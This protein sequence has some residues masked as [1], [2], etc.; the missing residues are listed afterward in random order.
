MYTLLKKSINFIKIFFLGFIFI[1]SCSDDNTVEPA[2]PTII[3]I[4]TKSNSDSINIAGANVVLYN[5]NSGESVSRT[6]S[7]NNG[8][9]EFQNVNAGNYYVRIAA[10]GFNEIPIGNVSPVPFSVSSGQTFSRSYFLDPL[11]GTYG[12]IDGKI[13]PNLPGFLVIAKSTTTNAEVHT[14]S[15]P[16]GYF[17]LFNVPF[18]TYQ[19]NTFKSGYQPSNNPVITLS[20]NNS[21]AN[22]SINVIQIVGSK[23]NGKV[24]F[25]AAENGIV[26]ISMLDRQSLSAINGLSTKIDTSRNYS[27]SGIPNGEY[28]AW[29]SYENDGYVMDPDWVFKNPGELE[30][31]F[32]SDTTKILNFSVTD[33]LTIISPTNPA[34]SLVPALVDTTVPT[35]Y[36]NAY[37]QAKEYIIEVRDA[38]GNLMWGGF[39]NSGVINHTQIPKE[40]NSVEY[41]FDGSAV[42]PLIPGNVYQWR[43]YVDD[44][45]TANIQT[46]LSSSEDLM[47]LFIIK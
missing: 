21:S 42:S 33:A 22:T 18:D 16:D 10:Q 39:T 37:P 46:L 41:N 20:S 34:D 44:A 8:I 14:Y 24:T 38:N 9:A 29:A 47:G 40:W 27:L 28:M 5:A 19:I 43:I 17:A 45:A 13:I 30:I 12:K 4:I 26:D 32:I 7:G 11:A 1:F 31:S 23:L 3:Q 2:P 35:F 6:L 25:L 36:W 15:G